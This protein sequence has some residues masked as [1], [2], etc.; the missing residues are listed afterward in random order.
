MF[1][2]RPSVNLIPEAWT[3]AT[4]ELAGFAAGLRFQHLPAEVVTQ[5]KQSILDTVGVALAGGGIGEGCSQIADYAASAGHSGES[6]IWSSGVRL[7]AAQAALVN[8]AHARALDYDDIIL[9]PQIHVAACVVPAAL[10]IAQSRSLTVKGSDI[11]AA[12]AAGCE[13]QSR[14]AAAIAPFFGEGLPAMLSSQVFGYFSAAAACG[15]LLELQPSQMQSAFGLALMHAA[16]TEEMV[17]HA[18]DSVG[19]CLY[20]GL[21]NQGGVQSAL[22]S[23]HGVRARGEALTGQAGLFQAYYNGEYDGAVLTSNLNSQFLSTDR[24][25]KAMPGTLVSHAFAEAALRLMQ[26]HKI[27]AQQIERVHLHVGPWGAVMCEPAEMRRRPS[28]ASAAM[29][30]IPFM[31]SKTIVNGEIRLDDF[32]DPGRSQPTALAMASRIDHMVDRALAAPRGLEAGVLDFVLMDGRILRQRVDAPLGHPTRPISTS[33]V[34]AKFHANA[35]YAKRP[36]RDAAIERMVDRVMNLDRLDDVGLLFD[37]I[38]EHENEG[39]S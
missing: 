10:A 13:V 6:S 11:V 15:N 26:E 9:F 24:C 39:V 27:V 19:K 29:N 25:I 33:G 34:V 35:R 3:T 4:D 28:S 31:V 2:Q 17:V 18:S 8:A 7:P 14:L 36:R 22:M 21:S 20:A 32:Q 5:T 38:E 12:V 30:S 23:S 16:G 37:A 1:S